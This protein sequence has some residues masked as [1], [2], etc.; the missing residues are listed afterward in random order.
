MSLCHRRSR[1]GNAFGLQVEEIVWAT[2]MQM[3]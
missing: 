1:G 2:M 3:T